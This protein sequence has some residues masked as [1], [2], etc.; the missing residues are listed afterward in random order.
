MKTNTKNQMMFTAVV[1]ALSV[2]AGYANGYA[3]EAV[4]GITTPVESTASQ[5]AGHKNRFLEFLSKHPEVKEKMDANQDGKIDKVER[6]Q[7]R[8]E[9]KEKRKEKMEQFREERK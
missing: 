5:S 7:A 1:F 3:E 4:S 9:F 2:L 8:E 6:K